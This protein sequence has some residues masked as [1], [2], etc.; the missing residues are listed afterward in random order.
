MRILQI[1]NALTFGGA[2]MIMLDLVRKLLSEGHDVEVLAFRDGPVKRK[3]I[4]AGCRVQILGESFLDLPA[5]AR[6]RKIL[7]EFKP[8]LVHSHLFRAT[9]L[10]R[11]ACGREI[12]V[13]TSIHGCETLIYHYCE[14]FTAC[15]SRHLIFPSRFLRSWYQKNI[16]NFPACCTSIIYPGVEIAG[17]CESKNGGE[18]PV[19][20]TLSRLHPV[21]GVDLLIRAA[22]LLKGLPFRLLIGGDGRQKEQLLGLVKE[23]G[24]AEKSSF[25][26]E[27]DDVKGF[28]SQMDIFVAAS[29]QEAFGI[30][31]CEAMEREIPVIAA[32]TGGLPEIVK[33][34]ETGLLF[35]TDDCGQLAQSIEKMLEDKALRDTFG[36]ASRK[37][38]ISGFN[39]KIALEKHLELYEK[40]VSKNMK[41]H[42]AISSSELGGGERLALSLMK[43]FVGLGWQ[44]TATCSGD[45]LADEIR[46][47]GIAVSVA[48][49]RAGGIFFARRLLRDLRVH[50]PYMISSHLNKAS[51]FAGFFGRLQ[52][53]PVVSH[54]HGLNRLSYYSCS[55][56]LI[57]VSQAVAAHLIK[58][59]GD[60][61]CISTVKNC[62]ELQAGAAARQTG[63]PM[64]IVILAKLHRNK[65]HE[66]ALKAIFEHI[67]ALPELELH[68]VGDGPEKN[69]LEDL[70]RK[71]S[72]GNRIV[73]HGFQNDPAPILDQ[74]HVALL[75]S[76]GEG[77]PLSLLEAMSFGLPVIATR[78]GG[79]PEI[80]TENENGFLITPESP[81]DL[82]AA[83]REISRPEIYRKFSDAALR[84]FS[85][86]NDFDEMLRQTREIFCRVVKQAQ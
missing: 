80:I 43:R 35:P 20:G 75:P 34:G 23:L 42:F 40:I 7:S 78:V 16:R 73:F 13:V 21:K 82:V 18:L 32:R 3:L 31:V 30:H 25:V 69:R 48:S 14:R 15:L 85:E 66:W 29:R 17:E 1:I 77:I 54:V 5:Y 58:Q 2:Q 65:G 52:G 28:I 41:V 68:I 51:M 71:S 62:I 84:K 86:L 4:E 63:Q 24:L 53:V 74:M 19:V 26:G 67:S 61:K 12:P 8:D 10:A 22:G 47:F 45:P 55:S 79:I 6:I 70:C 60:T 44:I 27:V 81:Q 72:T 9:F 57:A 76:L 46:K 64:K 11:M 59:G 50:K 33:E 38:I 39:R 37:R 83:I 36:K 49:Q 56:H